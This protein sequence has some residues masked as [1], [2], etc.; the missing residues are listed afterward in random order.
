MSDWLGIKFVSNA[1]RVFLSF[2]DARKFVHSLGLKSTIQWKE[3][4]ASKKRP[5]NIPSNPR[6]VYKKEFINMPDWLGSGRIPEKDRVYLDFIK[7][8]NFVH[9]LNLKGVAD[10]RKYTKTNDFQ[11]EHLPVTPEK[12]YKNKGW[13]GYGDFL[14]TGNIATLEKDFLPYND[15]KKIIQ[16]WD[17]TKKQTGWNTYVR[18]NKIPSNIPKAPVAVYGVN[19]ISWGDWL[20]TGSLSSAEKSKQFLSYQDAKKIIQKLDFLKTQVGWQKYV[21]TNTLPSNIPVAPSIVYKKDFKSYRL[22]F[23]TN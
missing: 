13:D 8:R 12:H 18:K 9:P 23:Y 6:L 7:A 2:E 3:Y 15:A 21:R 5:Q 20:G 17:F 16:K 11:K 4:Y 22:S 14:G 19:W 1:N 10:W